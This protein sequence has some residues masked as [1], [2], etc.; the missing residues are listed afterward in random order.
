MTPAEYEA[1]MARLKADAED[2][3]KALA[4]AQAHYD[5]ICDEMRNLR[6]AQREQQAAAPAPE[7]VEQPV[8]TGVKVGQ[9]YRRYNAADRVTY[10]IRVV[11]ITPGAPRV[12]VTSA[13]EDNGPIREINASSLHQRPRRTGYVLEAPDA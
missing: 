10:R 1:R 5:S 9:V 13:Y 2:A 11:E 8:A 12:K 6:I 7:A 4:R 3:R